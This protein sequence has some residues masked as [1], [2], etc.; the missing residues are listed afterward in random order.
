M[1]GKCSTSKCITF[2]EITAYFLHVLHD[3]VK[4]SGRACVDLNELSF[5]NE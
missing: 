2:I 5:K 1:P 4:A 3:P